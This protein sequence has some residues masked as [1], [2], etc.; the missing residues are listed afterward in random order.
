MGIFIYRGLYFGLYDSL[1]PI[2]FSDQKQVSFT[3]A[4]LLGWFVTALAGVID[5]PVDT[6]RRRMMMTSGQAVK[7]RGSIDCAVK[8]I[9]HEGFKSMMRGASANVLRTAAGAGV[10]AGS[11]KLKDA[12]VLM[13]FGKL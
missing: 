13:K 12:Y 5:Y 11:D 10:L 9:K 6:V 7:Y 2:V 1:K 4:F 8:I 3:L